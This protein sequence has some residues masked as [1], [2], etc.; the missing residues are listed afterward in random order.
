MNEDFKQVGV[1][2]SY[3]PLFIPESL[4]KKESEH[5]QGFNPEVAWVTQ[6]GDTKLN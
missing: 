3:F 5:V 2:N 4:L 1:K 6:A